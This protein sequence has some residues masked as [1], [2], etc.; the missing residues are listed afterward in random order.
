MPRDDYN[1]LE[2]LWKNHADTEKY[3]YLRASENKF[4]G[5][6]FSIIIDNNTTVVRPHQKNLNI[7]HGLCLDILPLDGCAPA[8]IKRKVQK[9]HALIYSL[10]CSRYVP[11]KHGKIIYYI[12][13]I[14]LLIFP[15]KFKIKIW[16]FCEKQ[17]TKYKICDSKNITE[18]CSGPKYMQLEYPKEI[19]QDPVYKKFEDIFIPLP[20][21]YDLYL[22]M[23]FGD[24]MK[25]PDLKNQKPH[26]DI[27]FLDLK[28]SYKIHKKEIEN[29]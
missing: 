27:I 7:P 9:I 11:E 12:S 20:S 14:L 1:K 18:L 25:L 23:A 10:F 5:N 2:N 16:K 15:N 26:H 8:G 19:F 17:M 3:S 28:N 6:I 29:L 21:N 4:T 22:K 24:Y 13:K